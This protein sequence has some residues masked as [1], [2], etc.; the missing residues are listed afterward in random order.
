MVN[1]DRLVPLSVLAL[2]TAM[3][4]VINPTGNFPVNDDWAYAFAARAI[5]E[6]GQFRLTG[7]SAP[8]LFAQAYWGALF[9]LPFG[10]SHEALRLSTLVLALLG[11]FA[12]FQLF[13]ELGAGSLT[14][15]CATLTLACNPLY[16]QLSASFMTDV[17][18]AALCAVS[19]W[20]YVRGVQRTR[21]GWVLAAYGAALLALMVRQFGLFLP[22]SFGLA[23]L[24]RRGLSWRTL[25][26]AAAQVLLFAVI[27]VG[28]QHWVVTSGRAPKF[29]EAIT[30]VKPIDTETLHRLR[31]YPV[32]MLPY[33]GL[34]VLPFLGC[35][36][37]GL[38]WTGPRG[39]RLL[40]VLGIAGLG[41]ALLAL[42]VLD[43][44]LLPSF[45]NYLTRYGLGPITLRDTWVLR[46]NLP[47]W[48]W[49][50]RFWTVVSLFACVSTALIAVYGGRLVARLL[51]RL[52]HWNDDTPLA[53]ALWPQAM[54]FGFVAASTLAILYALLL[55]SIFDRYFV[56]F[57]VPL[58][59]CVFL[60]L[61]PDE[62]LVRRR[63][64]LALAPVAACALFSVPAAHD[65]FA[66]NR[67]RWTAFDALQ[68]QGV[69]PRQIDGG[70]EVSGV[71]L[72]DVDYAE[73]DDVSH[74]WI[75]D[76]PYVIGMGPVPGY[77]M[78]RRFPFP[79]WLWPHGSDIWI[80]HRP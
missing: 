8:N 75:V 53:G 48:P 19:F 14:S 64:W 73:R 43:H 71:H 7:F 39:R 72:Y 28:F 16:L 59:T 17:P 74:W 51:V 11:L 36:I 52:R 5:V 37:A 29:A 80:L 34:V 62:R 46:L 6:T 4:L 32:A 45:G 79:R 30:A 23:Y 21:P 35:A 77:Q 68:R 26:I 20:C 2:F 9:C 42:L 31:F 41:A 44:K 60:W 55:E 15:A 61:R 65:Y 13:R 58:C 25:G 57:V 10:F 76:D 12:T 18:F 22:L 33:F 27:H 54:L 70:F 67:A 38:S 78:E 56:A 47:I 49:S 69:S 63:W 40:A 1:A 50:G 66:F 24:V 3:W